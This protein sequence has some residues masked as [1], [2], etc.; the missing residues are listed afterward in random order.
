MLILENNTA[1]REDGKGEREEIAGIFYQ[2][3]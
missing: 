2:V 1:E 3:Q